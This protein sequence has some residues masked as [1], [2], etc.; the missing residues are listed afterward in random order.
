MF[1]KVDKSCKYNCMFKSYT[2]CKANTYFWTIQKLIDMTRSF[3]TFLLR[4]CDWEKNLKIEYLKNQ[5]SGD[6]GHS[7]KIKINWEM[8]DQY[9]Q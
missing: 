2:C 6:I 5:K 9:H 1:S 8:S 4:K 7:I 3:S